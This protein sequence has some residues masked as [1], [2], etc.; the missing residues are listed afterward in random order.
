MA[1]ISSTDG[2][3]TLQGDWTLEAIENVQKLFRLWEFST[4]NASLV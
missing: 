3:I 1:N 4:Q 2:T